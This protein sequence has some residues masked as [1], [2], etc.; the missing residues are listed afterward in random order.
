MI[1]NVHRHQLE[2]KIVTL[3]TFLN[4]HT[5]LFL[6]LEGGESIK[7]FPRCPMNYLNPFPVPWNPYDISRAAVYFGMWRML[8]FFVLKPQ[9]WWVAWDKDSR[10]A[11][12]VRRIPTGRK[13]AIE[14]PG[15]GKFAGVGKLRGGCEEDWHPLF[16]SP[17]WVDLVYSSSFLSRYLHEVHR[18][19]TK[20]HK[21]ECWYAGCRLAHREEHRLHRCS[22]KTPCVCQLAHTIYVLTVCFY[23]SVSLKFTNLDNILSS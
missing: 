15:A 22:R 20:S 23:W 2:R 11:V 4:T 16:L 5:C 14:L 21:G 6:K 3:F 13:E 9:H 10:R 18:P 8:K 19:N 17:A 12:S 7:K 1:F